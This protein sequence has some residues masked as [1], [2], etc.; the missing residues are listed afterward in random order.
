M[1]EEIQDYINENCVIKNE[2]YSSLESSIFCIICLDIIIEPVMCVN[3]KN[4]YCKHCIDEWS[5]KN[6][7]CP[8]RCENPNYQKSV[9]LYKLLSQLSFN[10][11]YCKKIISYNEMEKHRLS[12]CHLGKDVNKDNNNL[13]NHYFFKKLDDREILKE[14]EMELKS[15]NIYLYIFFIIL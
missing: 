1:E 8:N 14:P 11:K 15:K 2:I 4:V 9:A 13:E 6:I 7:K 5:K 10:C 3:C 12:K